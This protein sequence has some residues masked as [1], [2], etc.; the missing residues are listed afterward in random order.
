MFWLL[1]LSFCYSL[2]LISLIIQH[3]PSLRSGM[4]VRN[5][6]ESAVKNHLVKRQLLLQDELCKFVR[7]VRSDVCCL[8]FGVLGV[9]RSFESLVQD[10]TSVAGVDVQWL[11]ECRAQRLKNSHD[12]GANLGSDA[13]VRDAVV[14]AEFFCLA[15]AL[16]FLSAEVFGDLPFVLHCSISSLISE[17]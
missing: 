8:A 16:E 10:R 1:F 4:L 12:K 6:H 3:H 9:L 11:S 2:S 5:M 7:I 17:P 14:Y 13:L 15:A